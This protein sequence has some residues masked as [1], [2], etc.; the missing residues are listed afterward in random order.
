MFKRLIPFW[1]LLCVACQQENEEKQQLLFNAGDENFVYSGR[2]E[3]VNDTA[4]ALY[5][6][7]VS[8]ETQV[9]GDS[10]TIY[11]SAA[12]EP[13]F[14][15]LELNG[16]YIG[17]FR[18]DS[19]VKIALPDSSKFNSLTIY[20][21]TEASTGDLIFSGIKAGAIQKIDSEDKPKIEFIGNSI[22]CGMGADTEEYPCGTEDWYFQHNAYLAYGPRVARTL[23]ANFELNCVSGMGMYRNWNDEDQPVMGDVYGNLKLNADSTKTAPPTDA[24]EIVSIA[25]GTNDLSLGDGEKERSDFSKDKFVENYIQ[26]VEMI[27][28]RYP[29]VKVAL[30]SSPMVSSENNNLLMESLKEVKEHFPQKEIKV[31]EFEPMT[32]HGCDSHPD[33][34]DHEKMAQQL[35]PF[36]REILKTT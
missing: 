2:Y 24:P 8:V 10:A 34:E 18:S 11:L 15:A 22:T 12:N 30:L 1:V 6:S 25:L 33:V 16:E 21:A 7:A 28:N 23:D 27:Y 9:K 29:G 17:R 5:N 4:V 31:F 13:A 19:L 14:A 35:I 20:K 3:Q 26:F 36:F 32:P